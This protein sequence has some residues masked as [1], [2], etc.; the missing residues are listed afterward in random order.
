MSEL[1]CDIDFFG[2]DGQPLNYEQLKKLADADDENLT[3]A[4]ST[5]FIAGVITFKQS[6]ELEGWNGIVVYGG[7]RFHAF[8]DENDNFI[9]D[10]NPISK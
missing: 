4:I 3:V 6:L 2:D 1:D 10:P 8:F 5:S 7:E 9:T